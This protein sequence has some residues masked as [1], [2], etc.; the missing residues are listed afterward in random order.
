MEFMKFIHAFGYITNAFLHIA[1]EYFMNV[2]WFSCSPV[3]RHFYYLHGLAVTNIVSL[4]LERPFMRIGFSFL[5]FKSLI[6]TCRVALSES[7]SVAL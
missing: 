6:C 2:T 3:D 4:F 5:F 7:R 1:E